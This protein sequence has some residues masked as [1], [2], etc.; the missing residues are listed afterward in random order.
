M[1]QLAKNPF[2]LLLEQIR[3]VVREEVKKALQSMVLETHKEKP[4]P[5]SDWMRAEDL[6]KKYHLPKTFFEEKGR[7][8]L[9][10]RTKP[11]RYVLFNVRDVERFLRSQASGGDNGDR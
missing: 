7:E 1:S 5:E 8:G 11:G 3:E 2:E 6:A 10:E 9:I 4:A